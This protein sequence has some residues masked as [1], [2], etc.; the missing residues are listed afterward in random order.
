MGV[1]DPGAI[2]ARIRVVEAVAGAVAQADIVFE[3]APEDMALK[4][5]DLCGG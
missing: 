4:G 5:G 3:A 1:V 2:L